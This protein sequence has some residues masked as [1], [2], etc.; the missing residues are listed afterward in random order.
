MNINWPPEETIDYQ[1]KNPTKENGIVINA[2]PGVNKNKGK[3]NK[4]KDEGM[5]KQFYKRKGD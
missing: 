4:V 3:S 2:L 1:A 5:N